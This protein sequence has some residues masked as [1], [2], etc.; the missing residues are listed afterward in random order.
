MCSWIERFNVVRNTISPKVIYRFSEIP[1]K[2]PILEQILLT[3]IWKHKDSRELK[4]ILRK[5]NKAGGI[6]LPISK[7]SK[8]QQLSEQYASGTETVT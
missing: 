7:Y 6:E 4:K 8:K 3:F 1:I 2:A 5:K